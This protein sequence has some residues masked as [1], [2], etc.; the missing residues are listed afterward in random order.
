MSVDV[1]IVDAHVHLWDPRVTPRATTPAL[2]LLGWSPWLLERLAP[3]LFPRAALNFVGSPRCALAPFMPGDLRA[4]QDPF[5]ARVAGFIHVEAAWKRRD[6]LRF[7]EETRWLESICGRDLLGIVGQ[8]DLAHPQLDALLD[9]HAA[10]SPRFVGVR[11]KVAFSTERGVMSWCDRPGRMADPAWRRGFRRLGDRGL[12]FDAW[13]YGDQLPELLALVTAEPGTRVVL[14]H[15]GSPVGV[16]DPA[17][18]AQVLAPWRDFIAALAAH[19]QVYAK[20]SGLTMPVLGGD[21]HRRKAEVTATELADHLGPLVEHALACFGPERCLFAS[22]SP[23]DLVSAP[24][25]VTYAAYAALVASR[26]LVERCSLF[27][28]NAQRLYGLDR[29]EGLAG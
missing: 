14:D 8:A 13:C 28:G 3:S 17:R 18:R 5:G 6:P 26:S 27:G 4:E 11:D 24:W 22:N 23:M 1:L 16:H 2:R 12:T 19:P 21:F 9:A 15:L 10:A 7:S 25:A 29:T 20:L